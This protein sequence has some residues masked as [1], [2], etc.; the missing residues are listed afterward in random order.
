MSDNK[1]KTTKRRS[2]S[3]PKLA[4]AIDTFIE[5][6]PTKGIT[7]TSEVGDLIVAIKDVWFEEMSGR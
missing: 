1:P 6:H 5:T 7:D 4:K 3:L 2:I